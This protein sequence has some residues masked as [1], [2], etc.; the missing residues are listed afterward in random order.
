M[1]SGDIG[2]NQITA[3]SFHS[4]PPHQEWEGRLNNDNY[5]ATKKSNSTNPWIQVDMLRLTIVTGI[6]TQGRGFGPQWVTSL[7]IQ[8]GDSEDTLVY[9]LENGNPK[10]GFMT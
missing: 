10:V 7:Q 4:S 2:N 8:Y 6:I 9:I 1:Q 3:S 5:W